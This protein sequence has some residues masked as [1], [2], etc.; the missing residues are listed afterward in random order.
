MRFLSISFLLAV[1]AYTCGAVSQ[2]L[3]ENR[4]SE[5]VPFVVTPP[6][7]VERMLQLSELTAAD[8]LVDLG[9]GDGR[10]VI[11]AAQRGATARGLEIDESLVKLSKTRAQAAG[12]SARAEFVNQDIF[13]ANYSEFSVVT[14]YLLPEFNLKLRPKLLKELKPGARIISHEWDM[15]EWKADETLSVR[16]PTKP[17]GSD[18]AHRV[19]LWIVPAQIA[20]AWRVESSIPAAQFSMNLTQ[21]FQEISGTLS[22]GALRAFALRGNEVDFTVHQNGQTW[23]LRGRATGNEMRGTMG[24]ISEESGQ[25]AWNATRN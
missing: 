14:M 19:Y 17:L 3:P 6:R 13:D 15:G 5:E 21:T 20:G 12:V 16:A 2:V 23:R 4:P 18:Y 24:R 11:A 9:S 25:I 7:V 10:I 1:A 8:R 22:A